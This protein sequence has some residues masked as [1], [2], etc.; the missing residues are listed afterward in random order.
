MK[1]LNYRFELD[2]F[3]AASQVFCQVRN[4]DTCSKLIVSLRIDGK[5]YEFDSGVK[6]VFSAIKPNGDTIFDEMSCSVENNSI[7]YPFGEQTAN[8]SGIVDCQL[9]LIDVA[10]SEGRLATPIFHLEVSDNANIDEETIV[11]SEPTTILT[12][13]IAL[14]A[15]AMQKVKGMAYN[16]PSS[17]WN[18]DYT[19]TAFAALA[20]GQMFKSVPAVAGA[21]SYPLY[22]FKTA[23]L[24]AEP[25]VGGNWFNKVQSCYFDNE[26]PPTGNINMRDAIDNHTLYLTA[27]YYGGGASFYNGYMIFIPP[28]TY[29]PLEREAQIWADN[30]GVVKKRTRRWSQ[31]N[32]NE[33]GD[34]EEFICGSVTLSDLGDD[35]KIAGKKLNEGI[36]AAELLTALSVYTKADI[37]SMIGIV[38][39]LLSEV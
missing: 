29:N 25:L 30:N 26:T 5:P 24:G 10:E 33:W 18:P 8:V 7:I 6:V 11:T 16:V 39:S 3:Q 4:G 1:P 21:L 37:N 13:T 35:V 9:I 19:S 12:D 15:S 38:E 14:A 34:F 2:F 23:D 27:S 28:R 31:D 20:I 36:T 32:S 17:G 22:Y